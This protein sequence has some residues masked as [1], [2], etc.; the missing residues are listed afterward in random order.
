MTTANNPNIKN[1]GTDGSIIWSPQ[2]ELPNIISPEP[3]EPPAVANLG[4]TLYLG[5]KDDMA[6]LIMHSSQDGLTWGSPI[7]SGPKMDHTPSMTVFK[8][9]LWIAFSGEPFSTLF[10]ASSPDGV[11]WSGAQDVG[12]Q[13]GM[14]AAL[15]VFEDTLYMV[16]TDITAS[17]L[18]MTK[19]DDRTAIWT[20]PVLTGL[21]GIFVSLTVFKGNLVAAYVSA[22]NDTMSVAQ[23][24][25]GNWFN[26]VLF[27]IIDSEFPL[28]PSLA[29]LD[30][31]I[32]L[33][34]YT[35]RKRFILYYTRSQ[36]GMYWEDSQSI[37][38]GGFE[39]SLTTFGKHLFVFF[40]TQFGHFPISVMEGSESV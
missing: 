2:T 24:S 36:D 3:P 39:C 23:Y 27:P 30:N 15:T 4:N 7:G 22:V 1:N 21:P 34:F 26:K 33:V 12:G 9:Q 18:M 10:S 28:S 35:A 6:S 32:Y 14:N 17:Q 8:N 11:T 25:N 5:Y 16:Y 31:Y 40:N 20:L 38:P 19:Y 37:G 13:K 29:T